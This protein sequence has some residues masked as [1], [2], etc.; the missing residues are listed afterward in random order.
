MGCRWKEERTSRAV[1]F[2]CPVSV[3]CRHFHLVL[4]LRRTIPGNIRPLNRLFGRKEEEGALHGSI[5]RNFP[6]TGS[7]CKRSATFSGDSHITK[8]L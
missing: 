6:E 3:A 5:D 4:R 2:I 7:T 1:G 8:P